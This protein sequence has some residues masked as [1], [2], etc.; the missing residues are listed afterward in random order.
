RRH[1]R[2]RPPGRPR[3]H[4][5]ALLRARPHEFR[6]PLMTLLSTIDRISDARLLERI[7]SARAIMDGAGVEVLLVY[8]HPRPGGGVLHCLSGGSA[9][10]G[11]VLLLPGE[12][13]GIILAAGPNN[14]R[15]FNQRCS[16]LADA[17][18]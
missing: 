7:A 12:G 4:P 8:S 10:T 1:R 9:G 15:V 13:R 17:R 3:D 11:T 18:A 6:N 2:H 16:F 5:P 14:S